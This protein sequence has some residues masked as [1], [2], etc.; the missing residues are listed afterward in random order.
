MNDFSASRAGASRRD[1]LVGGLSALAAALPSVAPAQATANP[2]Y[3]PSKGATTMS[4][5]T[6]KDGTEIYYKDWGTGPVVTFSHGWPLN[7][8]AWDGQM[9]F[10]AQKGFRV[11]AHDRR[12]HGR[13]SQPWHGNDMDTYAD[14]L[15][16]VVQALDLKNAIHVGHST[17]GGEVARYIGRH[18]TA[19]VAKAVLIGAIPPLMLRTREN[20]KGTPLEA[21]DQ[22]RSSVLADRSQFWKDLSLPFYGYNHP[23][24]RIS[25]GVRE[26]FRLQGMMAGIPAAYF[27]VKVFSETDLTEDLK[28]IDVPTLILHGDDDQIVPIDASAR[29]SARIVRDS[30]LEVYEGA[31]H[32]LCT[33]H[34]ERINRDLLSFIRG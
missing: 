2:P 7:S 28:R 3:L 21:F 17:G 32:G 23:G 6:T 26:S 18:G 11:V 25:E 27:C 19:R 12:G 30:V 4:T 29:L 33:T 15:A 10:L 9:L 20:P 8:D 16:A 34:K 24:A 1:V 31:P 5:I 22:I 13:S 14:D